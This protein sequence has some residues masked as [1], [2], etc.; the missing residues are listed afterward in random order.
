MELYK[1]LALLFVGDELTDQLQFMV[2]ICKLWLPKTI[3]NKVNA[4]F[5]QLAV[6]LQDQSDQ[7]K[8]KL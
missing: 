4:E 1:N 2:D 5:I 8:Q 7:I 6:V 3:S